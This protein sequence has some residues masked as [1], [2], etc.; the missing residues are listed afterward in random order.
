MVR[1]VDER[2]NTVACRC[3]TLMQRV[4]EWFDARVFTPHF[5]EALGED[6]HSFADKRRSMQ[7]LGVVETGDRVG[8]ARNFDKHS[9]DYITKRPLQGIRRKQAD[10]NY[11]PV[12]EV[13]DDK[14]KVVERKRFSDLPDYD[15]T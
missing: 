12:V 1:T 6:L 9:D 10:K 7:E 8:G 15:P 3:G 4:P 2:N 13:L 5:D 14:D 11:D